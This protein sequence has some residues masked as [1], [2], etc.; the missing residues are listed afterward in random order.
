MSDDRPAWMLTDEEKAKRI[1]LLAIPCRERTY[2][3][4]RQLETIENKYTNEGQIL[5]AIH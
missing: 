4:R 3:Q 1:W 2:D 5:D